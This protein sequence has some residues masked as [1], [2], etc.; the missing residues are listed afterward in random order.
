[1]LKA[2]NLFL[3]LVL[4]FYYEHT[5]HKTNILYYDWF[6]VQKSPL[7]KLVKSLALAIKEISKSDQLTCVNAL[8]FACINIEFADPRKQ[9]PKCLNAYLVCN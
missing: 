3:F 4:L 2:Q 9:L 6:T 1:M 5:S 8:V 7:A